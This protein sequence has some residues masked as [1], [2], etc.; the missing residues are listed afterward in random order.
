MQIII[1]LTGN[2]VIILDQ[3]TGVTRRF[4]EVPNIPTDPPIF[5]GPVQLVYNSANEQM[6][7]RPLLPFL[8][9]DDGQN[10]DF[11]KLEGRSD[12]G[13]FSSL[14]QIEIGVTQV[15]DVGMN[16][17]AVRCVAVN[18]FGETAGPELAITQ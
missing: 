13:T 5:T 17:T 4:Q 11:Y 15:F 18:E 7:F 10:A 1:D 2:I 16:T 8:V 3:A 9:T 14:G 6:P 12:G